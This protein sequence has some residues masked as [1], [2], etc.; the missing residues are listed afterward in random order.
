MNNENNYIARMSKELWDLSNKIYKAE[1]KLGDAEDMKREA[2]ELLE[3]QVWYMKEYRHLL[4][5]RIT[6]EKEDNANE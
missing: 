6:F 2:R 1:K 5:K 4:M 3:M